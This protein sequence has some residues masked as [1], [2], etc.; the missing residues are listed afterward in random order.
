L[1]QPFLKNGRPVLT[2]G[3]PRVSLI[4]CVV[5]NSINILDFGMNIEE[6]VHV[7]RFGGADNH[8]FDKLIIEAYMGDNLISSLR[9]SGFN[10]SVVKPW[11]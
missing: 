5:Q 11:N 7:P 8:D 2:S 1:A 9:Y 3:S 6:S 10:L 4:E